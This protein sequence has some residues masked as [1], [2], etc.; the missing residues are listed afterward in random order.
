MKLEVKDQ[1]L[2]KH[3]SGFVTKINDK[4]IWID[5]KRFGLESTLK[6]IQS[7]IHY[8]SPDVDIDWSDAKAVDDYYYSF[9]QW[10]GVMRM[11]DTKTRQ[12]LE[13]KNNKV[14]YEGEYYLPYYTSEVN[15]T[16]KQ[17]I[18]DG[19]IF[20]FCLKL[21][22]HFWS[23]KT[24]F[25]VNVF[26]IE[27][28]ISKAEMEANENKVK[29]K[30]TLTDVEYLKTLNHSYINSSDLNLLKDNL[31]LLFAENTF[32]YTTANKVTFTKGGSYS[33]DK[34]KIG[35]YHRNRSGYI[36]VDNGYKG[37]SPFGND[38]YTILRVR[39]DFTNECYVSYVTV[40]NSKITF[41]RAMLDALASQLVGVW[42]KAIENNAK[43]WG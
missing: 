42:D 22:N 27:K 7:V 20:G 9:N 39:A 18:A 12:V 21:K 31:H 5:N 14:F 13:V 2:T 1:I 11:G 28:I 37:A 25:R 8:K 38:Y 32:P 4:S 29:N 19:Y 3:G 23:N 15:A 16:E 10:Q 24:E 36:Q 41:D 6:N 17:F 34:N 40:E 33:F 30:K 26:Y 43:N 35:V